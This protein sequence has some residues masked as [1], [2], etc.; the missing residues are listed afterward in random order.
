MFVQ[1]VKNFGREA[2]LQKLD[3]V[4]LRLKNEHQPVQGSGFIVYRVR[5]LFLVSLGVTL[6][7][8]SLT[9]RSVLKGKS[10]FSSPRGTD[11]I[12]AGMRDAFGNFQFVYGRQ[13]RVFTDETEE[14]SDVSRNAAPLDL[15]HQPLAGIEAPR[16]QT[17]GGGPPADQITF[18]LPIL[19]VV[20]QNTPHVNASATV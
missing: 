16:Y 9:T 15:R 12:S 2:W 3:A 13:N 14:S 18:P 20:A 1:N 19:H 11:H 7:R 4:C 17:R 6:V 10:I 5:H 8:A